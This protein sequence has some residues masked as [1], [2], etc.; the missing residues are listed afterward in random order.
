MEKLL[1]KKEAAR[2]LWEF[3]EARLKSL[4]TLY[5]SPLHDGTT[6]WRECASACE[7]LPAITRTCVGSFYKLSVD[8][9]DKEKFII[10]RL[11][12][13]SIHAGSI[14]CLM[15]YVRVLTC[16]AEN[17]HYHKVSD[18][19]EMDIT[20]FKP[21]DVTTPTKEE[22]LLFVGNTFNGTLLQELLKG[23]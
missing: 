1:N 17:M 14:G 3:L 10:V 15:A 16:T 12:G 6:E 18:T 13:F 22:L 20:N 9:G 23:E 19:M 21:E 2:A 8:Y 11:E 7:I 4:R 5:D